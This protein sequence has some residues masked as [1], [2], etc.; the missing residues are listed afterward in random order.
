MTEK[1][2]IIKKAITEETIANVATSYYLLLRII[3]LSKKRRRDP[4]LR[5]KTLERRAYSIDRILYEFLLSIC[6]K[7]FHVLSLFSL[8]SHTFF[9]LMV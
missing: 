3:R 5:I 9:L 7:I 8:I 1:K 6:H 4:E 2:S